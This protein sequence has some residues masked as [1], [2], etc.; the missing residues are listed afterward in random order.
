MDYFEMINQRAAY[1]HKKSVN[2]IPEK[3]EYAKKKFHENGIQYE[4]KNSGI[5]HFHCFRKS[6]DEL[7]QFWVRTGKIMGRDDIRGIGA[8]IR[9]LNK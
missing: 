5:G 9:E 2:T 8:L 3:I 6:D 7:F 4:L 1:R